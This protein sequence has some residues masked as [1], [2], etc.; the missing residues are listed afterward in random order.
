MDNFFR[1]DLFSQLCIIIAVILIHI[2]DLRVILWLVPRVY[3]FFIASPINFKLYGKWAIVTGCTDGIGREYAEQLAKHGLNLVLISRSRE[4][5]DS[6]AEHLNNK[7][8][9]ETKIITV[10]FKST[11]DSIYTEIESCVH[12]LDI[13]M[14]INNVGMSID[15]RVLYFHECNSQQL[16]DIIYVNNISCVRLTYLILPQLI[17]KKRG[18]IVNVSSGIAL[19]P[20]PLSSI[21][22]G[23]KR[24]MHTF[25]RSL[26]RE[27]SY[28]IIQDLTPLFVCSKLSKFRTPRLGVPDPMAYV[29]QALCSIGR[30][31][32]TAGYFSHEIQEG[33]RY[34]TPNF[35]LSKLMWT[36]SLT[37][38]NAHSKKTEQKNN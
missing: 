24:L 27:Y 19:Y 28:L 25:S 3:V 26:Q 20:S 11:D 5:L 12:D 33:F 22:C 4:K 13:G 30:L 37:R 8:G 36:L 21:Y 17:A 10:D 1:A 15:D 7:F 2:I 34:I 18:I 31:S 38:R 6:Q 16:Q 23:T 14:L 29:S 35:I 9:V 32:S